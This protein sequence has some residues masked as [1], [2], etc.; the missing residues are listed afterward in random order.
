MSFQTKARG[1][2]ADSPIAS[3]QP[4]VVFLPFSESTLTPLDKPATGQVADEQG[5]IVSRSANQPCWQRRQLQ[6]FADTAN[7]P[8]SYTLENAFPAKLV[9][10][11]VTCMSVQVYQNGQWRTLSQ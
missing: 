9:P 11:D 6:T 1:Q 10:F 5:S 7:Y 4:R 2:H 3:K 8:T